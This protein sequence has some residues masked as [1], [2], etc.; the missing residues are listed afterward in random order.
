[1]ISLH[2]NLR[3]QIHGDRKSREYDGVV[4]EK[5]CETE[6]GSERKT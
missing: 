1:M 5:R 4:R 6:L 2:A 3:D